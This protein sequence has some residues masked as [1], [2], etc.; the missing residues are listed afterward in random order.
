M[1]HSSLTSRFNFTLVRMVWALSLLA[2]A[3]MAIG[4]GL[5]LSEFSAASMAQRQA[6]LAHEVDIGVVM[7]R[8]AIT[9]EARGKPE[10]LARALERLRPARFGATGY[11]FV[12][13][14]NGVSR[15]S[16][17]APNIEGKNLLD[18]K[19][20]RGSF[21]F[22][23]MLA[24]ARSQG[25]GVVSYS[26]AKPGQTGDFDKIS[27]VRL[28]PELGV[29][30]G[31][32]AYTDDI[33]GELL[34]IAKSLAL[35]VSPLVLLFCGVA[36]A[37][38]RLISRRLSEMAAAMQELAKG[39]FNIILPG[40]DR[41]D[42]LGDMAR[43]VEGFK[44]KLDESAQQTS[45][46]REQQRNATA[47]TRAGEM[48][49]LALR[50]EGAIGGV[51][52]AVTQSARQ[53]ETIAR[54]LVREA[55]HSG[56]QADIGALAAET[57]SANVQ[58]VAAAA[59]ELSYSVEEIGSQAAR[60]HT[61]SSDAAREAETTSARMSDLAEAIDRI[62]GIVAMITGI[63]QQTNMLALNA[64][65]EA[66]RAGEAG[67]GFA[68]VAQEVK[69]LAEQTTRA[70]ADVAAQIASVQ[71]ASEDASACI[72]AMTGATLEVSSI[73]SAIAVSV[74]SQGEATREIAHSVQTTSEKT[75]ELNRVIVD[76][77]NA[78]QHAGASAEEVLQ[79]VTELASQTERLRSECDI[80]LAQVRAV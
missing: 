42:E 23:D 76:V 19:D 16:P 3:T 37:V 65:I 39:N 77:R 53:L 34:A 31:A 68:V 67:R 54:S 70:T 74:G 21:P 59:E 78:S 60:S 69:S 61:I 17:V 75:A 18:I 71:K 4:T 14:L 41:R 6:E 43:A 72:S 20:Q 47:Q 22:K 25:Q 66:A 51:V 63:A 30:V 28:V 52:D 9:P 26:W 80:F 29:M 24:M 40:L 2:L 38:G 44:I 8:D 36:Y 46:Q 48:N 10:S 12:I 7:L 62:G 49:S 35:Y 32:G 13:D 15:L 1:P 55:R 45:R 58:S 5:A 50:F 56:E 27:Y 33:F 11:Y 64:T 73:A 79:S 57:A